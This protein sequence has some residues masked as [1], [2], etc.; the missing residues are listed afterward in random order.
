ML[1]RQEFSGTWALASLRLARSPGLIEGFCLKMEIFKKHNFY[2]YSS[3]CTLKK[4]SHLKWYLSVI[5]VKTCGSIFPNFTNSLCPH[6]HSQTFT[7]ADTVSYW[8]HAFTFPIMMRRSCLKTSLQSYSYPVQPESMNCCSGDA[9]EIH[10]C[11]ALL[12]YTGDIREE[13]QSQKF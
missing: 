10:S 4:W 2:C 7:H 12:K 11:P 8:F 3:M 9:V 1:I 5:N 13:V 6:I